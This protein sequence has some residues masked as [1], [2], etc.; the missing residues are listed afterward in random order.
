MILKKKFFLIF[1]SKCIELNSESGYRWALG[2]GL[3]LGP[4]PRPRSKIYKIIFKNSF[5]NFKKTSVV[6][7]KNFRCQTISFGSRWVL[8]FT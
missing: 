2:L 6:N 3:G 5:L 7:K 8:D 1:K 4:K